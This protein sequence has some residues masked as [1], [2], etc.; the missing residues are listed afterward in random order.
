[1][2]L[3]WAQVGYAV[4][5]TSVV[6]Y[7]KSNN[8]E[9]TDCIHVAMCICTFYCSLQTSVVI[10]SCQYFTKIMIIKLHNTTSMKFI[11]LAMLPTCCR[12]NN[13][14]SNTNLIIINYTVLMTELVQ[15]WRYVP[16]ESSTD[17]LHHSS[18]RLDRESER[19]VCRG[20]QVSMYF[21]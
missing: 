17:P 4:S 8:C 12:V 9:P 16:S 15:C 1:M 5:H 19:K 20:N 13:N 10:F 3:R 11:R 21:V 7:S 2:L 14:N 6:L 18:S